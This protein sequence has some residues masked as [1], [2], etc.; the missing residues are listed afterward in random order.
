MTDRIYHF[1]IGLF[2]ALFMAATAWAEQVEHMGSDIATLRPAPYGADL[3]YFNNGDPS[4]SEWT[5]RIMT[6]D[7]VTVEII[8]R[9][10]QGGTF[11]T[12]EWIV[13]IPAPPY[14]ANPSEMMVPDGETVTFQIMMA[15]S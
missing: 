2:T 3:D 1:A 14:L 5:S 12:H 10:N 4:G 6:L 13:V 8:V 11:M 15:M 7:G 9:A